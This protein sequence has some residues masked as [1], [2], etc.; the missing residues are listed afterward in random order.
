[1][2]AMRSRVPGDGRRGRGGAGWPA[3]TSRTRQVRRWPGLAPVLGVVLDRLA[4]DQE[5]HVLP[6][7]GGQV[8]D[9]LQVA[10]DEEE[11]H[12]GADG[13]R[14]FHHVGQQDAE[15][16]AVQ[17]IDLVVAEADLAAGRGVA[18]DEGLERVGQHLARQP[19]HLDDLGLRRDRRAPGSAARPIARC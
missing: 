3:L 10:A 12:A 1:M 14:I 6:D 17:R 18:P 13:V 9:P 19:G 11:L 16:R 15:H 4:F 8:G 5:D 7:V 2:A